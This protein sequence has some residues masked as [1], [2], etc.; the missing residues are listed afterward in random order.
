MII[1]DKWNYIIN[2]NNRITTTRLLLKPI[3]S[4]NITN[5][6]CRVMKVYKPP[7]IYW[8]SAVNTSIMIKLLLF[9]NIGMSDL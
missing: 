4:T 9:W 3:N 5:R 1:K 8:N 2:Y 7:N 6:Y